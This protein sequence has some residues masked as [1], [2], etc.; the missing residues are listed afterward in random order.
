MPRIKVVH[1]I[2]RLE[3]GGAQINTLYTFEHLDEGRF[4]VFLLSGA[5]GI[6][7]DRA[8]EN[9][10]FFIV[11][12][13]IREIRPLR[14]IKAFL[15]IRRRLQE[16]APDIVHTH[17]TKAGILGRLAAFFMGASGNPKT[18][19]SVHGFPFSPFQSFLKRNFFTWAEKIAARITNHFVFVSNDDIALARQEKLVKDNY[20]R[21]RS[22]FPLEKFLTKGADIK[23]TR[24]TYGIRD[25]DFVCGIIAPFKPQKGLFHLVEIAA[26]VVKSRKDVVFFMA[27]DGELRGDIESAL[28]NKGI[29][30]NFRLPGF[31]FGIEGIMD[32]FDLGVSTALWEGLPQSLVQLRLKKK[33]VVASNI[34]GN[35]EVIRDNKNGL[36]ADVFDHK[37][38]AEKI[39]YLMENE[40]ERRRLAD[41]NE[42]FSEWEADFMVKAQEKLYIS[43]L[44]GETSM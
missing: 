27:G 3:L 28:K 42:D 20:S 34:P 37:K 30:E 25:T 13:L 31:I 12:D 2:T 4:E 23:S 33:A 15:Q 26:E 16:I 5:G 7:T 22:G 8:G 40:A 32:I 39:L 43:L 6:L 10:R 44:N 9:P 36:L 17:S 29:F 1:I 18:I 41:F 14:D 21:I 35:R 11:K 19:H 24:E 38:F